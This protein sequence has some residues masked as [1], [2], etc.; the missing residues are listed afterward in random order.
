MIRL[1][2]IQSV[3][4]YVQ[5]L[6]SVIGLDNT[7]DEFRENNVFKYL[8]NEIF[9]LKMKKIYNNKIIR[10][11]DFQLLEQ[12]QVCFLHILHCTSL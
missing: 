10:N 8:N 9:L 2:V 3:H 12:M 1:K 7:C 5:A 4:V 11:S 6:H